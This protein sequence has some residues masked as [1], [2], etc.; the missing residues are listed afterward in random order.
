MATDYAAE[1]LLCIVP[2]KELY[3]QHRCYEERPERVQAILTALSKVGITNMRETTV[4]YATYPLAERLERV[5]SFMYMDWFRR[6]QPTAADEAEPEG[7]YVPET[8]AIRN[9]FTQHMPG[10]FSDNHINGLIFRATPD[11]LRTYGGYFAFDRRTP[12]QRGT[13]TAAL[14][15]AAIAMDAA[16]TMLYL[17]YGPPRCIYALCRP[18]GHHAAEDLYGG[19]CFF[20]NAVV[21]A[22]ILT[23]GL[24]DAVSVLD[25]DYHHGNGTQSMLRKSFSIQYVSIHADPAL[26]GEPHFTGHTDDRGA[27]ANVNFPL[28][29]GDTVTDDV[30]LRV[31]DRAL[32]IVQAHGP[33]YLVVSL[34]ADGAAGDPYGGW[35]LT[36]DG[37]A[38]MGR[39]VQALH[40]AT[41]VI[42][43][44]GYGPL[45][46]PC[47]A[48]FLSAFQ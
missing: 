18:P 9:H 25:L 7:G 38:Q 8:F 32:D 42:Q 39:R 13:H 34:G 46:G 33:R 4:P 17:P 19:F 28:P 3:E 45:L 1:K 2:T 23:G 36:P 30:Y 41:V 15:S 12:I 43:E 47:V 44:G 14:H 24:N 35:S 40:L 31:L 20:N 48:A 6:L 16:Q 27:V 22:D 11:I 37:F 29:P 10:S 26:G 5:H 21:A